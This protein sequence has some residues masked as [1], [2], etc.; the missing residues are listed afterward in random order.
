MQFLSVKTVS[1]LH[2]RTKPFSE[3]LLPQGLY[4]FLF[5]RRNVICDTNLSDKW[6]GRNVPSCHGGTRGRETLEIGGGVVNVSRGSAGLLGHTVGRPSQTG[7]RSP[8]WGIWPC[9]SAGSRASWAP[10]NV[11]T[12]CSLR[13]QLSTRFAATSNEFRSSMRWSCYVIYKDP[14]GQ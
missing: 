5:S 2:S 8:F 13:S 7:A 6:T 14:R 3:C 9:T 12:N 1:S 4:C 11:D 10:A